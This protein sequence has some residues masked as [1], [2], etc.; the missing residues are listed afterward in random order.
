MRHLFAV[1]AVLGALAIPAAAYAD[2]FDFSVTGASGGFSGAGTLTASPNGGDDFLITAITGTGVTGLF[3]P[4]GFNGNDNLLFP[5]ASPTLDAHGFS[6][7]AANGPDTFDVNLFNN[8]SGYFVFLTD[9]DNFN[10]ILP[11]TFTLS[12]AIPE[13][14]TF[15]LLGTGV[16]SVLGVV[17]KQF[18][19]P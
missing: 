15:L 13:P 18:L 8:G 2:T 17:R 11:A 9:E 12:T 14:S 5:S 4:N 1:F 6:F 3:A 7:S 16:L 19:H 10:E